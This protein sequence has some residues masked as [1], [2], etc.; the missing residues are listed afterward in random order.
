MTAGNASRHQ[1]RRRGA[2]GDERRRGGTSADCKPLARIA[3]FATAGVDPAMMGTGPIPAS[4]QGARSAPAG[5]S[6]TST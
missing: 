6:A 3:A 4:P 1:R 5:R 2:G